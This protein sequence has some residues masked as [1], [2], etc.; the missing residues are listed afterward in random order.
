MTV[1]DANRMIAKFM[2]LTPVAAGTV[3][4]GNIMAPHISEEFLKYEISWDWLMPVIE[5]ISKIP[6]IHDGVPEYHD[7]SYPLTFNMPDE[8]GNVMVR[9]KGSF[10]NTAPTLIEA[11]YNAVI[12][13]IEDY[14]A[15][16]TS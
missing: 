15:E 16:T 14:N 7:T 10:L 12:E 4:L 13:F 11:A 6:L 1:L 2:G 9:F 3:S 8:E 5:K